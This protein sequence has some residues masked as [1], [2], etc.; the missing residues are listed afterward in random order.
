[1]DAGVGDPLGEL[2]TLIRSVVSEVDV[3]GLDV[4]D[5]AR[6]VEECA[7]AERLL[8]ALRAVVTLSLEN[9]AVWRRE[10]YRSVAAWM[11]AKTGTAVGPA[12]ATLEMAKL[13]ADMP[14]LAAR[15]APGCSRKS[16]RR[17][18]PRSSP[19]FPAPRSTW[20]RRRRN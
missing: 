20:W 10:G 5:A 3:D 17:R 18:L 11:A 9:K 2:L 8:G 1:M 4:P 16:R 6:L 13:L 7:E 15:S 19:K 14:V 12:V